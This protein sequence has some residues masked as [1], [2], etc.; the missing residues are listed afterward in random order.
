[1]KP[2][3]AHVAQGQAVSKASLTL[4]HWRL[5]HIS[6][7]MIQR[8][9]SSGIAEGM[10][11]DGHGM[12]DCSTCHKGKQ[13]RNPIL[14]TIQD[15]SS[16]ILERVFSD[17]CGPMETPSIK[18]Y[19]YFITFT[20]DYSHYTYIGFCKTKHDALTLFK[21]W[22]ACTE[23]ETGKSLKTLCTDTS[24]KYTVCPTLSPHIWPNTA[25]NAKS[26]THI[27]HRKMVF[28]NVQIRQS[29]LSPIL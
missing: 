13:T 4:W 11:V 1:M 21:I 14:H 20:N 19:Q 2:K 27:H 8:M 9:A 10:K 16:E 18:G 29:V 5:G 23:K 24:G 12:G 17:L 15:W 3:Q 22:R 6:E 26:Q 7:D 28:L 25:S